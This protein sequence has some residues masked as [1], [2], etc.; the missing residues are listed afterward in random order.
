LRE[1]LRPARE[2]LGRASALGLDFFFPPVCPGCG[3]VGYEI[4]PP[5]RA[6]IVPIAG[7]DC[8]ICNRPLEFGDLCGRCFARGSSL[9]R[10]YAAAEYTGALRES[11]QRFKY[12]NCRYLGD[13]LAGLLVRRLDGEKLGPR[14]V[15]P[16]PL[17]RRRLRQRGYN[18]SG[19][20]AKKVARALGWEARTDALSRI[21]DGRAQVGL[22]EP[23]RLAN[24]R[25]AFQGTKTALQGMDVL[26]IDDVSTT[27]AT[28]EACA[29]ACRRAGASSVVAAVVE[30]G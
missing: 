26:L 28:L 14:L 5:C 22:N 4:C 13:A 17:H 19:I 10:V 11:V 25:R 15:V 21:H 18:Q 1:R 24:V 3:R 12:R 20:L 23:E 27:G 30:R 6:G 8:R 2:L 16:V 7:G 29:R 9:D